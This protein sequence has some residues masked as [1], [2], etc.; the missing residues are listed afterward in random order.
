MTHGP[1]GPRGEGDAG[2]R[3]G[4]P[5]HPQAVRLAILRD[6]LNDQITFTAAY[7]PEVEADRDALNWAL[8]RLA[9]ELA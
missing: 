5:P 4:Q 7:D 3:P 9:P 1:D 8:S 6:R 2:P